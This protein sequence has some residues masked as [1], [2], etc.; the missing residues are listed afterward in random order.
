MVFS[1]KLMLS[2]ISCTTSK[3]VNFYI[4]FAVLSLD[5]MYLNN[6]DIQYCE[7]G[8]TFFLQ[9]DEEHYVLSCNESG[10]TVH[11]ND[12]RSDC[13]KLYLLNSCQLST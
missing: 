9:L 4:I 11:F 7:L 5:K 3:Y 8:I 6:V 1:S 2:S 12:V 13:S 10:V